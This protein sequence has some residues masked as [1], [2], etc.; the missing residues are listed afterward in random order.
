MG[1]IMLIEFRVSNYKGFQNEIIFPMNRTNIVLGA[2]GSGKTNLG[3]AIWKIREHY[4]KPPQQMQQ[5]DFFQLCT[6]KE[7]WMQYTFLLDAERLVYTLQWQKR[8][9]YHIRV[10]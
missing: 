4:N 9:A 6:E 1:E 5:E 8:T 7:V 2:G 10:L 3:Q